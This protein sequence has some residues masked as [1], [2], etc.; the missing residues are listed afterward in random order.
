MPLSP[1]EV[2][3]LRTLR[4]L[5]D[6]GSLSQAARLLY[7]TQ[8][9]LSHQVKTL[10]DHYGAPLFERKTVP[11]RFTPLG[12]KLLD[13]ADQLVPELDAAERELLQLA[14]GEAGTLRIAVECHTCFDWLM[15]VMDRFRGQWPQVEL[16]IVSGFHSDPV[17]LLHGGRAD[18]AI[19]ADPGDDPALWHAALFRFEIVA[20]M[21]NDHPL[22]RKRYLQA[23]DF[24][25]QTLITYAVPDARLDI[26]QRVLRPAGVRP[27]QRSTELTITILQLVASRQ[28]VAAL[29]HW[30]VYGYL[31]HD[32]VSARPVGPEGLE[33]RLYASALPEVAQRPYTRAFVQLLREHCAGNL[34]G[35]ELMV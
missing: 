35:I 34:P 13:L 18:L 23:E 9:A 5:R 12:Q 1:L 11:V 3:H 4:A 14:Q 28:G 31:K 20:L 29:P 17:A 32:Y 33:S 22:T 6:S 25:G 21:A 10:E 24:A 7:L 27:R 8:S 15:P 19:V 16:D 26:I 30:A 2:R